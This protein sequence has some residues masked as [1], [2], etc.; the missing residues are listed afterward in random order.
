MRV[1]RLRLLAHE[2]ERYL[3]G[4][5]DAGLAMPQPPVG[6]GAA[7]AGVPSPFD[8]PTAVDVFAAPITDAGRQP[9]EEFHA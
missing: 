2:G 7:Q 4:G 8:V 9:Q 3:A 5:A 6:T 1:N